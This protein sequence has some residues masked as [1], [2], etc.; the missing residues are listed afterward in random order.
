MLPVVFMAALFKSYLACPLADKF[1]A[2]LLGL[3]NLIPD[4]K[5][6][7]VQEHKD[8]VDKWI[9]RSPPHVYFIGTDSSK[10]LREQ[11]GLCFA[12]MLSRVLF[13]M[14][15]TW[16]MRWGCQMAFDIK[17]VIIHLAGPPADEAEGN[18]QSMVEGMEVHELV[19][20][21]CEAKV[22]AGLPE[23][24]GEM[25]HTFYQIALFHQVAGMFI[26]KRYIDQLGKPSDVYFLEAYQKYGRREGGPVGEL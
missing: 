21:R 4:A 15:P 13:V 14:M 16:R 9:E 7:T 5:M 8:F 10:A 3:F 19:I 1:T 22:D 18:H 24:L 23:P 26:H 2:A 17:T 12:A 20:P 25:I 11:A 6:A